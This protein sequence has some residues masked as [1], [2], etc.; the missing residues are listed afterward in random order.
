MKTAWVAAF[1]AMAGAGFARDLSGEPQLAR[2][3]VMWPQGAGLVRFR[4]GL[5]AS[6][7]QEPRSGAHSSR[8]R[9]VAAQEAASSPRSDS[10]RDTM[11]RMVDAIVL[12]RVSDLVI[13]PDGRL[14]HLALQLAVK[15][16]VRVVLVACPDRT[17]LKLRIGGVS[18]VGQGGGP[19]SDPAT[20][21]RE[22]AELLDRTF[23][24]D[25][26]TGSP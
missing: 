10:W 1:L 6:P 8:W 11:A 21:G 20:L 23:V 19:G 22:V 18:A 16:G 2:V 12:H 13:G 24:T 14:A 9:L 15:I 4:E 25:K 3:L 17:A 5:L 26:T 7:S